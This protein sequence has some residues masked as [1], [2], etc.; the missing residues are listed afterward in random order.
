[1]N[2]MKILKTILYFAIISVLIIVS[3]Y[4]RSYYTLT[5]AVVMTLFFALDVI[6]FFMP[7]GHIKADITS[8]KTDYTKGEAAQ[9]YITL[10]STYVFPL[11]S[12]KVNITFKNRFYSP[13]TV[14]INT[15]VPLLV[16]QKI[17]I[18]FTINKAGIT[19]ITLNIMQ[20]SDFMGL[21]SRKDN[22]TT[23]YAIVAMPVKHISESQTFGQ[24]NSD[25]I[26]AANV[27]LSSSGD[28]SGY[29]EYSPG[30]RKNTINWKLYARTDNI[31]V[32]EF[33]RTSADES[34]V[35]FDMYIGTIDKAAEILYNIDIGTGYDLLW[36]PAGREDFEIAYISDSETLKNTLYK[37]FSSAPEGVKGKAIAE[38][39]KLYK[40]NKVLYI[41]DKSE[42]L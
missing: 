24:T 26:P 19:D 7:V 9:L 27:Y 30:D 23:V 5:G 3:V 18:P 17:K 40:E 8:E 1:M 21:F 29:K 42:L 39:K 35:L 31:Y 41:S 16:P 22:I 4:F 38:Y 12:V 2:T 25:E 34:V 20:H 15:P 11:S 6:F 32:K 13:H 14:A 33:D 10:R 36:L 28:I 37:I